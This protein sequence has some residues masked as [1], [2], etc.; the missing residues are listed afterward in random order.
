M[1][2]DHCRSIRGSF[3][4]AGD[5][6]AVGRY[7]HLFRLPS[8]RRGQYQAG[9]PAGIRRPGS[10]YQE[11]VQAGYEGGL[12]IATAKIHQHRNLQGNAAAVAQA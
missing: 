11:N 10:E 4:F 9:S 3:D 1:D 6:P 2:K 5:L 8:A 12:R 7:E